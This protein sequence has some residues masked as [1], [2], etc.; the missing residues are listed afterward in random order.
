MLGKCQC[1]G[2]LVLLITIGGCSWWLLLSLSLPQSVCIHL[3]C[4]DCQCRGRVPY[5]T[6]PYRT[7]SSVQSALTVAGYFREWLG[8]PSSPGVHCWWFIA[9]CLFS[10]FSFYS[11]YSF[12]LSLFSLIFS[13]HHCC[14]VW[15]VRCLVLYCT[16]LRIVYLFIVSHF[17]YSIWLLS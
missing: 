2:S 6:V 13:G 15:R 5:C 16:T 4:L 8:F 10:F 1:E 14:N 11:F 3:S 9:F 7:V 12:L 17:I